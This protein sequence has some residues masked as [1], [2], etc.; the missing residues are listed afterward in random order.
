[1][2]VLAEVLCKYA[3]QG[4]LEVSLKTDILTGFFAYSSDISVI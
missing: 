1:M 3:F 2:L 4:P